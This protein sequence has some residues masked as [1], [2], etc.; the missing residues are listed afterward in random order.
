[1]NQ[2][3]KIHNFSRRKFIGTTAAATAAM[4][5]TPFSYGNSLVKGFTTRFSAFI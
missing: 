3:D 1:M 4:A 2:N 5:F